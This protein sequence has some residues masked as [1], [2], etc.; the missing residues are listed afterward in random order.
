MTRRL[1]G[2]LRSLIHTCSAF[3]SYMVHLQSNCLKRKANGDCEGGP[4]VDEA[5]RDYK[6][7]L[8]AFWSLRTHR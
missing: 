7:N 3:G 1:S 5:R 2:A 6:R 8:N 4:T